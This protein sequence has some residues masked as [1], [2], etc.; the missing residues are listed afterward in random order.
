MA[1]SGT[2]RFYAA[3]HEGIVVVAE[4]G[5]AANIEAK[6]CAGAIV[7]CVKPR[8][9][10]PETVFAG[11]T[12][13]GLYRSDD[14]GLSW[15]KVLAGDVRALTVDPSDDRVIYV[16]VEPVRLYR[17]ED[18]GE[19]FEDIASLQ[20]LPADT[21]RKLGLPPQ[22]D[23]D[24]GHPKFRH[25]RQ[26]WTFPLP[27]HLG[28]VTEIFVRP[29][30]PD[31]LWLAIEH[32][33]VARSTDRGQ[34]WDD[35]SEGIDYL[36]IHKVMRLP[37]GA[38]YVCSSARGL[39]AAADPRQGWTRAETGIDRNYF[40]EMLALPAANGGAAPLLVCCAEHSPA[41]W[42][43]TL[44]DGKWTQGARGA[45]AALYR[46]DDGA[47][48]W[49]RIGAGNGLAQELDPMIWSLIAHPGE[50]RAL[51]AG[52]GEVGRGYAFG[53]AGSGAILGSGDEGESWRT[54][55]DGLP[56]LRQLAVVAE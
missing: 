37:G 19:T 4:R 42:E 23:K 20:R 52:L 7:D 47:R 55:M 8:H 45:R 11:V 14:R 36:D 28:H 56:A 13:D 53:T 21:R 50:R 17:S 5:G 29:D 6:A 10:H 32:G 12:H 51:F 3:T 38:R 15:R 49:R 43:A 24:F 46:S 16:G 41:R 31:E 18:G 33:G 40:H 2:L 26:E 48:S 25:G 44:G 39:Y 34:S 9:A 22:G 54:V 30:D 35:A 1:G 27:P